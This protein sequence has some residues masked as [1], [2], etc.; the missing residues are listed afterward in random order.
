[1]PNLVKISRQI[2]KFSTKA[3]D[4]DRSVSIGA[5]CYSGSIFGGSEKWAASYGEM[6][7]CEFQ[8]DNSKTE[9]IFQVYTNGRTDRQTVM[10]KSA[11]LVYQIIYV[12]IIFYRV[13]DVSYWVLQA[14]VANFRVFDFPTK[15]L[16]LVCD[17]DILWSKHWQ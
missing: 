12:Y 15:F 16:R 17:N 9:E 10:A 7:M 4:S 14:F 11:Q 8:I 5:I 13:S 1:M 3:R 2:K 6:N